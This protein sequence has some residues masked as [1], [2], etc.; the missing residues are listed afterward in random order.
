[1]Q[2]IKRFNKRMTVLTTEGVHSG[3]MD[4]YLDDKG[5]CFV[6][7]VINDDTVYQLDTERTWDD[8]ESLFQDISQWRKDRP[9]DDEGR[10]IPFP[11]D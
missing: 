7:P 5:R 2:R 8:K 1:M 3:V 6:S 11:Q 9:R 10:I 4:F